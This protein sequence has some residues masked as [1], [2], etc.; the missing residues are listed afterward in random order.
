MSLFMGMMR[1]V[2][3]LEEADPHRQLEPRPLEDWAFGKSSP[4]GWL[5]LLLILVLL[6]LVMVIVGTGSK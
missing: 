4:L 3:R 5:L 1:G 6:L 2:L